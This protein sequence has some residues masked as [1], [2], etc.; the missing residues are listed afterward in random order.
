MR[1]TVSAL[2][3]IF[4][5]LTM[6]TIIYTVSFSIYGHI[7]NYNIVQ[8]CVAGTMITWAIKMSI[9]KKERSENGLYCIVCTLI[10]F[11]AMVFIYLGVS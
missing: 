10:A 5:L 1:K 3:W 9:D 7:I 2:G 8:V 6:L 11:G 4:V